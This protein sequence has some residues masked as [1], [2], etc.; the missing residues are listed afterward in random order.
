MLFL[1]LSLSA[2]DQQ[3]GFAAALANDPSRPAQAQ[4]RSTRG[5]ETTQVG[6]PNTTAQVT[7]SAPAQAQ[8]GSTGGQQAKDKKPKK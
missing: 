1:Y 5:Q 8:K 6:L 3:Q 7:P 2:Q 4:G